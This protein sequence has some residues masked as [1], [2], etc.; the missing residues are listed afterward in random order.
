MMM[1]TKSLPKIVVCQHG[2]RR[3]YAVPRLFEKA[4]MLTALFT[5]SS[6]Y[7]H[8]G[9]ISKKLGDHAPNK[10]KRLANRKIKD[11]SKEK[12]YSSDI[13]LFDSVIRKLLRIEYSEHRQWCQILSKKMIKW[14]HDVGKIDVIYNMFCENL[15]FIKYVRSYGGCKIISDVYV[16][17]YVSRIVD[18]E[19]FKLGLIA[20]HQGGIQNIDI[21]FIREMFLL[22]DV[23]LCPSQ[24][25]ADGVVDLDS[26]FYDKIVICPY[27]STIDYNGLVSSPKK[28]R[29]LWAGGDWIR[30]GLHVLAKAAAYLILKYP[31]ME[32]RVAGLEESDLE[33]FPEFKF[34]KFLGRLNHEAMRD[35]FL[36]ADCLAIPSLAEGM[37]GVAVEA[38]AAGCPVITTKSSGMDGII[39]GVNGFIVHEGNENELASRIEDIYRNRELRKILSLNAIDLAKNYSEDAWEERLVKVIK[40]LEGKINE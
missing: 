32:F 16:H 18:E 27:G 2:A 13:L 5:D 38:S 3:R 25:V 17:P 14:F 10:I 6:E 1:L 11:V 33:V 35:E 40:D 7:S 30:K 12:I 39:D 8:L 19:Y 15:D 4:G 31:E 29:V 20:H 36:L 34:L 28:G 9:L 37:A 22:S 24:F 26:S 21:G 23:L